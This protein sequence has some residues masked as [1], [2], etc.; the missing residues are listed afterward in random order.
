MINYN[1]FTDYFTDLMKP[2]P[3]IE[4]NRRRRRRRRRKRAAELNSALSQD[5]WYFYCPAY[6]GR[7]GDLQRA[8]GT[9]CNNHDILRSYWH[10]WQHRGV[11]E[12]RQAGIPKNVNEFH[13][14]SYVKRY[15][16]LQ[17]KT[18]DIAVGSGGPVK[19]VP[20]PADNMK[21]EPKPLNHQKR[22]WTDR[23]SATV[24]GKTLTVKRIDQPNAVW[25]QPLVLRGTIPPSN[26]DDFCNNP[27]DLKRMY[28]HW[29]YHGR[30]EGRK[31]GIESRKSAKDGVTLYD[32]DKV[33]SMNCPIRFGDQIVFSTTDVLQTDTE[34]WFGSSVGYI[35]DNKL[36]WAYGWG[37]DGG[38]YQFTPITLMPVNKNIGDII[39]FGDQVQLQYK[40]LLANYTGTVDEL[41]TFTKT[42]SENINFVIRPVIDNGKKVNGDS[43]EYHDSF[44][45]AFSKQ[46]GNTSNCGY[47]GCS[48]AQHNKTGLTFGHGLD[49]K[50]G[51]VV[52]Y[53]RPPDPFKDL[54]NSCI[55]EGPTDFT[56]NGNSIFSIDDGIVT[57]KLSRVMK[58]TEQEL[59][60]K[61]DELNDKTSNKDNLYE[62]LYG[63]ENFTPKNLN[64]EF[65]EKRVENTRTPCRKDPSQ[66]K[67]GIIDE[68]TEGK[69][70]IKCIEQKH[71]S[72][73][74]QYKRMKQDQKTLSNNIQDMIN[75]TKKQQKQGF[76]NYQEG[77]DDNAS[78]KRNNLSNQ[79]RDIYYVDQ[80][81]EELQ[82]EMDKE[83]QKNSTYM[84]KSFYQKEQVERLRFWNQ[85]IFVY[86]YYI[87][88]VIALFFLLQQGE[89]TISMKLVY[90]AIVLCFPFI[91]YPVEKGLY[92]IYNY[93]A[94]F[95][96]GV[97]HDSKNI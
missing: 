95:V 72:V 8:F 90:S 67:K 25:G 77:F 31:A 36:K 1:F 76:S 50:T 29:I 96:L 47:Y 73:L 55:Q 97:P 30:H 17:T 80:Q 22:H 56:R 52:L 39:R 57:N 75:N 51:K 32:G 23:F 21:V 37:F 84:Q 88:A 66:P 7:Y 54:K 24:S 9:D 63:A 20:L 40:E 53:A 49:G 68:I 82:H 33:K 59:Q 19:T 58:P 91:I 2:K 4:G 26:V 71:K 38:N 86:M 85:Y 87:L 28:S 46:P 42:P 15:P 70:T 92:W 5:P 27:D 18:V 61:Q 81:T 89:T 62:I 34:G 93:L 16:G 11:H 14:N 74:R 94:S 60:T 44:I 13:C 12:G 83:Q 69:K 35:S 48:V 3:I 79:I 41:L 78:Y 6:M 65:A 10:H 43:F 64:A 45:L